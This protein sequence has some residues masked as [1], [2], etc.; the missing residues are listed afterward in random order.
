MDSNPR[1]TEAP[2]GDGDTLPEDSGR[3]FE[4]PLQ[5][6]STGDQVAGRFV[7]E[8]V[9]GRG[10][11]GE[12]LSAKD[13]SLDRVIAMKV[14]R[15][16]G[17]PA[18]ARFMREA[19]ITARLDHPN[20]PPVHTLDFLPDGG[21]VFTMR[22]LQGISLG[23]AIRQARSG[24][25]PASIA[26]VNAIVSLGLRLCEALSRAH[27]L[28]IIHRDVKPDNVMLGEH[29]EIAL[30]DWGE[31]RLI[32][33]PAVVSTG[34][35][36][37]TPA[38]MSPEQARGEPAD[39]SSDI[40]ALGA[41]L[42]HVLTGE[43][44]MWEADPAEFWRRKRMGSCDPLPPSAARLPR[45]LLAILAKAMAPEPSGRYA[46]AADLA[47]DLERFQA[48]LAVAA[49]RASALERLAWWVGRNRRAIATAAIVL[50]VG[51]AAAGLLWRERVRQLADW[52]PPVLS[53]DFASPDWRERWFEEEPGQWSA[54]AGQ[55]VST[56]GQRALLV[57]DRVLAGAV[58]VE[59]IGEMRP[60][61]P[62]GDLSVIW[63]EDSAIAPGWRLN[64]ATR[65][66]MIQAGA[67]D[68][69]L[70]AVYRQPDGARLDQRPF[71]LVPGVRH[72]FRVEI[73]GERIG[74]WVDGNRVL[75]AEDRFPIGAGRI[76]LYAYYPGKAFSEVRVYQK[77]LPEV[78]SV[79]AIGQALLRRDL[80]VQ[81]AD[82]FREVA[83]SHPGKP[84]AA[85]AR[86]EQGVALFRG[87]D[88]A[89]AALAWQ[90]L[91]AG[92]L[93]DRATA[94]RLEDDMAAG[95]TA[96][97]CSRLTLLYR[98]SPGLRRQ[99]QAQWQSWAAQAY[100]GRLCDRDPAAV[101]DLVAVKLGL[102]PGHV[103]SDVECAKLLNHLG[104]CQEVVERF[105]GEVSAC[106]TALLRLG[107]TEEVL[108]RFADSPESVNR[109]RLALGRFDEVADDVRMD[110]WFRGL[111]L[112]QSGRLDRMQAWSD[113][114]DTLV[115]LWQGRADEVLAT[116]DGG[117]SRTTAL[118]AQGRW[119]EALA[120]PPSWVSDVVR[121]LAGHAD[122]RIGGP[123]RVPA[124][125][126]TRM[127]RLHAAGDRAMAQAIAAD[128]AAGWPDWDAWIDH[129]VVAPIVAGDRAVLR[130]R[131]EIAR[132]D[133]QAVCG[134]RAQVLAAYILG[135]GDQASFAAAPCAGEATLWLAVGNALRA[136]LH[137]DPAAIR[138][139]WAAYRAL[140]W[141]SRLSR[142]PLPEP[143]LEALAAWRATAP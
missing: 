101:E 121:A 127:V 105:P 24:Q 108:T 68:N 19:R 15:G 1:V 32:D 100:E 76:C 83:E 103:G 13:L 7:I 89:G 40:Y 61:N 25:S 53:E 113:R 122:S 107:R 36:V 43:L 6:L 38:Y 141:A 63:S 82:A 80:P 11:S 111:A 34:S 134:R 18:I 69:Y 102:F 143:A 66:I 129:L 22:Q 126:G 91:P 124:F 37:G 10:S 131:L 84:L 72:R 93:A 120:E 60:G 8:G 5:A 65:G 88:T 3:G 114:P 96:V 49:Y 29:G 133:G 136:E 28:G 95:R 71:R 39:A 20:V 46:S 31:S 41:T 2:V 47:T 12:V 35:A 59:Y 73:D 142:R 57:L 30:V 77:R 112:C 128:L 58:A 42:H 51:L 97:A 4:E 118:V 106:T 139:A 135:E 56:S 16:A 81:A 104:R 117:D 45:Q 87:G 140:P 75:E 44:P 130:R 92:E 64:H 110:P 62:P 54:E 70:C 137:G 14:L 116:S 98:G 21:L 115:Q 109:A 85:Q 33:D 79:L 132:K 99:L 52:G 78:A 17:G 86:F 125:S 23:E 94:Y 138:A 9:L 67:F 123:S 74:M 48:G 27:F 55:I 26:S 90:Q 50:T 119:A